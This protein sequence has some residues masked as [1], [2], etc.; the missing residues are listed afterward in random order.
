[1]TTLPD[2]SLEPTAPAVLA[3]ARAETDDLLC[4][5]RRGWLGLFVVCHLIVCACVARGQPAATMQSHYL[6]QPEPITVEGRYVHPRS[7]ITIP[8]TVAGF[9]RGAIVRYDSGDLDIS[10]G[11]DL[12]SAARHIVATVYV[13][14]APR[15]VSIGSPPE[16]V[17]GARAHLAAGEFDRRKR[18]VQQ[19]HPGAQLVEQRDTVRMEGGQSYSGKLAVFEYDEVFA[20]SK[21]PLRSCL[22]VF[23][24]VD[25][26]W[27]IEYRFTY[28]KDQDAEKAIQEFIQKWNWHEAGV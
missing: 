24:Y 6:K 15:L 18:E 14:P 2:Q 25:S 17:A 8:E 1:M 4:I 10:A 28:P 7:K 16:V 13:Y 22:Y 19:V 5:A 20:G 3:E 26:K 12:R 21:M 23:C 11:Y 9:W 27:A